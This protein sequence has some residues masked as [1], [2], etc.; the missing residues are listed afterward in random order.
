MAVAIFPKVSL[1]DAAATAARLLRFL[2]GDDVLGGGTWSLLYAC[3]SGTRTDAPAD[4]HDVDSLNVANPWRDSTGASLAERDWFVVRSGLASGG[5]YFELFVQ[6]VNNGTATSNLSFKLLPLADDGLS[7]GWA[8]TGTSGTLAT[9]FA[10]PPT[11]CVP[12]AAAVYPW[13]VKNSLSN[14]S[15]MVDAATLICL[16]DQGGAGNTAGLMYVGELVGARAGD[17][18]PF[19]IYSQGDAWGYTYFAVTGGQ[20]TWS[21]LSPINNTTVLTAG[22]YSGIYN[23]SIGFVHN[24][25]QDGI[26]LGEASILPIGP[27]FTTPGHIHFGGFF[28]HLWSVNQGVLGPAATLD[29]RNYLCRGVS[30]TEPGLAFPWDGVTE[31]P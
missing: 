3:D 16:V 13:L 14:F 22:Y 10:T 1:T 27:H 5:H 15:F 4:P 8:Y 17:V 30:T 23:S 31:Y 2:V 28:K 9:I 29:D 18:R 26:V 21:R 11:G 7:G 12:A 6:I 25:T 19:V 24:S 20:L